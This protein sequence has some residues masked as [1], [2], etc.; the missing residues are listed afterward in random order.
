[1]VQVF[2]YIQRKKDKKKER[3]KIRKNSFIGTFFVMRLKSLNI[4]RTINEH[5]YKASHKLSDADPKPVVSE[6]TYIHNNFI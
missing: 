3:K 1:M 4:A 2:G 5:F 6:N